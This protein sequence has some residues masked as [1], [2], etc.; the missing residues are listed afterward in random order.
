MSERPILFSGPMVR[1]ILDGR[2][3]QTRRGLKPQIGDLD[4]P[5]KMD[6]GSWR[7]TDS[8]GGHMSPIDVRHRIGD[9]LWVREAYAQVEGPKG[10]VHVGNAVYRSDAC[11]SSGRR[12][13]S[14]TPDDPD[15]EVLWRPSIYMPRS[16]SRL[17]LHVTDVRVQRLRKI[18]EEDAIAEGVYERHAVGDDPMHDAWTWDRNASRFA[19]PIAA[20]A[21][22]WNLI[23]GSGAWEENPWVAAITFRAERTK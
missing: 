7:V 3:T 22:L 4:R 2:K 19:T 13:F 20:F 15:R 9:R 10:V 12:W 23:N 16:L 17:T 1:A 21:A 18:S 6:D 8:R 5:F 14:I 11:D